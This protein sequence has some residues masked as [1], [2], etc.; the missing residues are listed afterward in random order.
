MLTDQEISRIKREADLF[1]DIDVFNYVNEMMPWLR[2][3]NHCIKRFSEIMNRNEITYALI[4]EYAL[5]FY[6]I[7]YWSSEITYS[8]RNLDLRVLADNLEKLGFRRLSYSGS[9]IKLLDLQVN[10]FLS[11]YR[12]PEPLRW[13]DEMS[14]KLVNTNIN[15]KILSP[16]DY[17]I[18]LIIKNGYKGVE[19]AAKTLYLNLSMIDK[20]YLIKRA[21][22]YD[23]LEEVSRLL[24]KL[25]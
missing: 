23:V 15:V 21:K 25:F 16:E 9:Y 8:I 17:S 19:L 12:E 6:S 18:S 1:K 10:L 13:D 24:E 11:V 20:D 4:G 5:N 2:P 22:E 14:K 3:V 7:P